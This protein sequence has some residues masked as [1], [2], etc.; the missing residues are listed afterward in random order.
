MHMGQRLRA[1]DLFLD[2]AA[3][4]QR[5]DVEHGTRLQRT[6]ARGGGDG[7]RCTV[8]P[9]WRHGRNK[10]VDGWSGRSPRVT[11]VQICL[12]TKTIDYGTAQATK[13]VSR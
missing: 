9:R 8:S 12:R 7:D 10:A 1:V 13:M 3:V 6:M 2:Q 11:L 5:E 4:D